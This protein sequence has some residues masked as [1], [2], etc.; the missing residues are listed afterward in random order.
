LRAAQRDEPY[1]AQKV[2]DIVLRE[3]SGIVPELLLVAGAQNERQNV[4]RRA[5]HRFTRTRPSCTGTRLWRPALRTRLVCPKGRVTHSDR[6]EISAGGGI[7][8]GAEERVA[9]VG[10]RERVVDDSQLLLQRRV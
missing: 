7:Y 10:Q 5:R 4:E 6:A 9:V 1:L 8:L 3:M 2:F